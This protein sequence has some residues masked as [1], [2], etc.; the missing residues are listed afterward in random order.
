VF[1][2][3]S[4][5]L[6]SWLSLR[7]L[8]AIAT[9]LGDPTCTPG[10]ISSGELPIEIVH[11]IDSIRFINQLAAGD[12]I[13]HLYASPKSAKW[14]VRMAMWDQRMPVEVDAMALL[15]LSET[16]RSFKDITRRA[17]P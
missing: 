4:T 15:T 6:P 7:P 3:S 14:G 5:P 12:E 1:T 13:G 11:L 8:C 10:S 9:M 17:S 16:A 2:S